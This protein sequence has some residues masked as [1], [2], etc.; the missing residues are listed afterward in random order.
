MVH[1]ALPL[2][3]SNSFQASG[4]DTPMPGRYGCGAETIAQVVDEYLA[5]SILWPAFIDEELRQ[6]FGQMLN[7]HLRE[8]FNSDPIVSPA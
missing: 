1:C 2:S 3:L 5:D 7:D 8:R 6:R 4:T